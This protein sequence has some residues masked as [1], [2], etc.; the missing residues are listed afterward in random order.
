MLTDKSSKSTCFVYISDNKGFVFF[1]DFNMSRIIHVT[2]FVNPYCFYFKFD[3]DLHDDMLQDLE[4]EISNCARRKIGKNAQFKP[5]DGDIV[6]AFVTSWS[7]WVRAQLRANLVDFER[8]ELWAIDHG[9]M[10]ETE[11]NNVVPLPDELIQRNVKGVSQGC[12]HGIH[13]AR[14]VRIFVVVAF[15][16][17]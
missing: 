17:S 6:A 1:L 15:N 16:S 2:H 9:K 11:Y 8:Y 7:K 5:V 13:P 10:F 12:I 4:I 3:D 14:L